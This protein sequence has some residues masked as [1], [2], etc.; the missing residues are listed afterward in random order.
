MQ[1]YW[2][3]Q[4]APQKLLHTQKYTPTH[5]SKLPPTLFFVSFFFCRERD[6]HEVRAMER[7]APQRRRVHVHTSSRRACRHE[8]SSS[9][10]CTHE[11]SPQGGAP[12]DAVHAHE[13]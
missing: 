12:P 11:L 7:G 5:V 3:C 13:N 10:A 8:G 6:A 4:A 1:A 9:D 2:V